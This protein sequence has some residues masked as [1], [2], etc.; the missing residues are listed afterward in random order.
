MGTEMDFL[1]EIFIN[2]LQTL[3]NPTAD[4]YAVVL[5]TLKLSLLATIFSCLFGFP[6]A[7]YLYLSASR[8]KRLM[9]ALVNTGLAAPP[10]V[11]GLLVFLFLSRQGPL[12]ELGL[13]Y[14]PSAIVIAETLLGIP[15]VASLAYAAFL[16]IPVEKF[17]QLLG[18]GATF[19]KALLRLAFEVRSSMLAAVMAAF[20]AII[21]EVGAVLMV[22]GNLPGETRVLT[23]AIVIETRMGRFEKALA[24]AV[25]LF[26]LSLIFNYLFTR[27]QTNRSENFWKQHIWR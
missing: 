21:S 12:G 23:T 25:I 26:S 22:G 24:L 20:G 8:F 1:L 6:L 13:L 11:V 3:G 18:W 17:Y 19:R 2:A 14:T 4:I 15:V 7:F 10:V 9:I 5:L 16:T 27:A